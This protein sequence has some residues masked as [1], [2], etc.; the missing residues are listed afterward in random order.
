MSDVDTRLTAAFGA[1]APPERD[2]L[3]RLGVLVRIERVRFRRRILFTTAIALVA[4]ML[5]AVNAAAI[6]TWMASD[7]RH[8]WI[9]GAAALAAI[10]AVPGMLT[11]APG[12]RAIVKVF[13]RWFAG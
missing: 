1:D 4:A 8:A 6:D 3:F 12:V 9:T 2:A 7:A 10:L 13:E 5:V 11:R